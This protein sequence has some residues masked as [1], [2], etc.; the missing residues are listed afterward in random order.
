[1]VPTVTIDYPFYTPR[2][3]VKYEGKLGLVCRSPNGGWHFWVRTRDESWEE[4]YFCN[5]KY[6]KIIESL[7]G[8]YDSDMRIMT[9][10]NKLVFYKVKRDKYNYAGKIKLRDER[11]EIF[12]FRSDFETVDLM[13]GQK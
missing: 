8:L 6:D 11:Y 12:V 2:Q 13:G 9:D 5:E 10:S 4:T 3:L 1:M 7:D